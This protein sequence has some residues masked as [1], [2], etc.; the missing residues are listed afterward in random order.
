MSHTKYC[1]Y[2]LKLSPCIRNKETDT[3]FGFIVVQD[4]PLS[5]TFAI[6]TVIWVVNVMATFF[7]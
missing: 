3:R 4:I 1:R 6:V 2:L 5:F 7:S